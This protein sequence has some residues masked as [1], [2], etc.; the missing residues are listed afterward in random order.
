M[1]HANL[2]CKIHC[3]G[4]TISNISRWFP[5]IVIVF[6]NCILLD[7]NLDACYAVSFVS[8]KVLVHASVGIS[9]MVHL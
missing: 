7:L 5:E 8:D 6:F 3:A 2:Q 1:I 9:M 4:L